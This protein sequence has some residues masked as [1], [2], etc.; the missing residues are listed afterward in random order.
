MS[1]NSNY[2]AVDL[3]AESGRVVLGEFD[4]SRLAMTEVHRFPNESAWYSG[5]L[6]WDVPRLWLEVQRGIAAAARICGDSVDGIG[7]DT[8]GLDFA[9]LGE[10]GAL[11]DNPRH[12]RD[13]RTEH[14]MEQVFARV[15]REE[16]YAQTGIQFMPINSLYHLYAARQQ[17][18]RLVDAAE[19]FL[20]IPDLFNYWL[21]GA[22]VCEY[23]N[24]TTTQLLEATSKRWATSL[25]DRLDIPSAMFPEV[26]EPG[27]ILGPLLPGV[28]EAAG[29]KAAKC[30]AVACHDTGA[31][32]AAI[33]MRPDSAYISSGT[34]SLLG[35][36]I[37][38]PVLTS[39]ARDR[40]FTN[41]GGVGGTI[42][43][44]KNIMGLWLLQGCRRYWQSRGKEADYAD[45]VEL[46]KGAPP[47]KSLVDP[48]AGSFLRSDKMPESIAAYCQRTGQQVPDRESH[49]VR[50]VLESL[51]MKYRYTLEAL[52]SLTGIPVREIRIVGGGS[53]NALLNQFT[54]DATGR[55]VVAGPEEATAAGNLAVQLL[56]TGRVL[57]LD[58]ARSVIEAS[59]A[60]SV[61]EPAGSAA[62]DEAYSRFCHYCREP[63]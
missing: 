3:G 26:V 13:P 2:V 39:A 63:N 55:R 24:A 45:L 29:I 22:Q 62:W 19:R 35:G 17:T 21:S 25:M 41:E 30:I 12:Y 36:E 31:A 47:L 28:A 49:Y 11:L 18:P 43:L 33:R 44:L 53:K 32:V 54:A 14:V 48:D 40:N 58:Q 61:F 8:W 7:V 9:L 42:R 37:A 6:H 16:I 46:A 50:C 20:T 59:S 56:A 60:I 5:G 1:Q 52:E 27:T 4:G 10:G 34:W 15:P 38:A 57:S 51:A 23:T